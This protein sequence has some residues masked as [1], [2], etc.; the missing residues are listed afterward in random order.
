M[1][2]IRRR[3][4]TANFKGD[5]VG[6][7]AASE[8]T[9]VATAR[10]IA[11]TEGWRGLFKGLSLNWVKGPVAVSISFTVF[12]ALKSAWGIESLGDVRERRAMARQ[13][14]RQAKSGQAE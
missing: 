7:Q 1:D 11:R 13:A 6:V 9:L 10:H 12:D 8:V 3:M 5:G 2:V 4:Q 14:A